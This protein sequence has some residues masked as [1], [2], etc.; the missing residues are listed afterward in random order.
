MTV[1]LLL[2]EDQSE[3]GYIDVS[4]DGVFR[5]RADATTRLEEERGKARHNGKHIC[6]EGD[7]DAEWEVSWSIEDHDLE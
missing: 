2:R 6:G 4:I 1:F 5:Q 3:H 7:D